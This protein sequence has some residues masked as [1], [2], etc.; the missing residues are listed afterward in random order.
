MFRYYCFVIPFDPE[1][2]KVAI[3]GAKNPKTPQ[4]TLAKAEVKY[5]YM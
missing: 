1:K 4:P 5:S 2:R 3:W